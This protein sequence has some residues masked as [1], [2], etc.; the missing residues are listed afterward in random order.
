LLHPF[1]IRN[2]KP[3]A[4]SLFVLV[5]AVCFLNVA[6][7]WPF[8]K[9][10]KE[11][12]GY[13]VRSTE[14]EIKDAEPRK[15]DDKTPPV[16]TT[17]TGTSDS[18]SEVK[19]PPRS[20]AA[21]VTVL[22][23]TRTKDSN[24]DVTRSI[25]VIDQEDIRNSTARYVPDLLQS[26]AGVVV[27]KTE[28]N[29]KGMS[30]DIR[31]FG[32]AGKSNVLVLVDGRRTNQIDLSGTDWSAIPIEIVERI[33]IIRG[34][35]A[36]L[37]G[38]NASGGV[39]NIVTKKAKEGIHA[40]AETEIGLHKYKRNGGTVSA[41]NDWA[42]GF[43]HYEN[44]QDGGWRTNTDYWAN[45]WFGKLGVGPFYGA[46]L[47]L[48]AGNHHDRY[49]MPGALFMSE[50]EQLGRGG[51]THSQD[52][53]WTDE[54]FFTADPKWNF[55]LGED[56]F[57]L[58]GFNTFRRRQSKGSSPYPA[59]VWSAAGDWETIHHIDSYEFQPKAQWTRQL[60]DWMTS[61]MTGGID[62]F[63]AGDNIR[64]GNRA[65]GQDKVEINK[66]SLGVYALENLSFWDKLLMNFGFRG[67]WTNYRFDQQAVLTN[68]DTASMR[69][70]AFDFGGGFH[71]NE[72]SLAYIDVS[73]SFRTPTTE[74]CYQNTYISWSGP[75]A[76]GLNAG[77]KQQQEMNYEIGA[78]DNT[79]KP[80]SVSMDMFL[81]DIKDELYYD[82][83]TFANSNYSSRTRRYGFEMESS[84][85]LF[86]KRWFNIAPFL[87]LTTQKP[88][89]K[90]GDYAN[91]IIPFV[92]SFKCSTGFVVAPVKG[93]TLST[94]LNHIGYSF[95]ISDPTNDA[96]K[97]K[98]YTTVDM[99]VRYTWRWA[100]AWASLTNLFDER[101]SQYA[102]YSSG[103]NQVGYYPAQ[104]RGFVSGFS[105]EY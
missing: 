24:M 96:A 89:F 47:E 61:K 78:R 30:V 80:L 99:K 25:S 50:I 73:R 27:S 72:R 87:N 38:D 70:A 66:K 21:D 32:E 53:G 54:T 68:L 97:V 62:F 85:K 46:G 18:K 95:A 16:D 36:V 22:E 11:S 81:A 45:D 88:Y 23:V 43:F 102:G 63:S 31:G 4:K 26:R 91:K 105:L 83:I 57:E 41:E 59:S 37:Y 20:V 69:D 6:W 56:R 33:E 13:G 98:A 17:A 28:D 15:P 92:P 49:G 65:P 19:G 86:E 77:L 2:D 55:E 84:L 40:K 12:T 76:G 74:E 44:T 5:L 93:L 104:G 60:T 71:Y 94:E 100:T 8:A 39:I 64:S 90:G 34:P 75:V 29:P 52:R 10:A 51:S 48:T 58:S 79:F 1:G 101:Y 35:S 14:T 42:S 9:K 67:S 3:L 82:P 103:K 7:S